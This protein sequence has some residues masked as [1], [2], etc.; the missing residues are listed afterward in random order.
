MNLGYVWLVAGCVN[1]LTAALALIHSDWYT[2]AL[3]VIF[4]A[5]MG[6]AAYVDL[7]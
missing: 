6:W 2:L 3:S 7:R 5:I 4:A 1:A